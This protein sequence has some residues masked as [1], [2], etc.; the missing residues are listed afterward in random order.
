MQI[1][2]KILKKILVDSSLITQK[3]FDSAK[4]IAQEKKEPLEEV[5]VDQR[6]ISDPELGHDKSL[7]R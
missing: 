1:T 6:F 3:N 4:K 5:I 7:P 2:E